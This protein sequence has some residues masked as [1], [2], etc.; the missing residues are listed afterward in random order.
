MKLGDI[1]TGG[2]VRRREPQNEAVV[3]PLARRGVDETRSARYARRR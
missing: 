2:A 3:E 1:L